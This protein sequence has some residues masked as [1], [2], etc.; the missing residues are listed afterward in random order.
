MSSDCVGDGGGFA[1]VIISKGCS[2]LMAGFSNSFPS[3]R[4][5]QSSKFKMSPAP[6]ISSQSLVQPHSPFSGLVICVTGLSK[7][8]RKQVMEATERLGGQYSPNLHPQCTH[9]VVQIS[10]GLFHFI[11][12]Q[13]L[14]EPFFHSGS[15]LLI[16]AE[17]LLIF[18]FLSGPLM[19]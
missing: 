5:I 12:L 16:G 11:S 10:F 13:S 3:F 2:K 1:E 19:Y 17:L 9:L 18:M 14:S 6:S 15:C 4:G 7:E 8:A